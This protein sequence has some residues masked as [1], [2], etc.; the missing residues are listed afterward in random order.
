ML[1][2]SENFLSISI[3]CSYYASLCLFQLLGQ[4]LWSKEIFDCK[5]A[6]FLYNVDLVIWVQHIPTMI[7]SLNYVHIFPCWEIYSIDIFCQLLAK[8]IYHIY[9]A[10]YLVNGYITFVGK[11]CNISIQN[12]LNFNNPTLIMADINAKHHQFGHNSTDNMGRLL[13]N[14]CN[15]LNLHF[16]GPNFSIFYSTTI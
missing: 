2:I 6:A 1:Y 13:K 9:L 15:T 10:I 5:I 12:T 8:I 11:S 14:T 3:D 16:L 4:F 7:H